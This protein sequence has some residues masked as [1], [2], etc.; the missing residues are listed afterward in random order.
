MD[1]S[2]NPM[3]AYGSAIIAIGFLSAMDGAMKTVSIHYGAMSALAWRAIFAL[4]V[5]VPLYL[6]TRKS[7]PSKQAMRYHLIRGGLMVPMSFS[8][9]WGLTY[10]PMAQAIALAFV[11]PLIALVL[12]GPL[13]KERIGQKVVAGSL[14]AFAGVLAIFFGQTRAELGH[15]A[16]LGSLSILFSATLYAFNMLLMRQQSQN[17][18]PFE[19]AY[20]YFLVAGVGFWLVALATEL[21]PFPRTEITAMVAATLLSIVGMLGLAWAYARA[22]AAYLSST[23]YSGFI[24]AAIFGWLL[25]MEIPSPYTMA[26]AVL[27]IIGCW[28][29]ARDKNIDHPMETA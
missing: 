19:I 9:F 27:I 3:L 29:A 7:K 24:W 15:E 12:A 8:F 26:G 16:M 10:V 18:G 5:V 11:A 20:Y 25:F 13:L 23:E 28:I 1:R 6:L 4:P 2:S 14:L 22:G 17:A 21:P